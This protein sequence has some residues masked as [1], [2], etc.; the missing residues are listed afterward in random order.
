MLLD[1]HNPAAETEE[2]TNYSARTL[3]DY[4]AGED[5]ILLLFN[6]ANAMVKIV[7]QQLNVLSILQTVCF[8]AKFLQIW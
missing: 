4:Q 6:V 5:V 1:V 8:I 7:N 3:Y 2:Q